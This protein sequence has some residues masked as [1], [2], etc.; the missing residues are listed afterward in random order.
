MVFYI[1]FVLGRAALPES[2]KQSVYYVM[3][4]IHTLEINAH[5]V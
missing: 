4:K 5:H 3:Y 1:D 2:I